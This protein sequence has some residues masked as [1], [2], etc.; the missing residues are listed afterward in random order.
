MTADLL[1]ETG[2]DLTQL[3]PIAT[4]KEVAAL[5]QTS[6]ASLAQDRYLGQ[7]IPYIKHGR[8]VRYL[9]ADVAR[10]LVTHRNNYLIP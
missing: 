5:L 9:R 3:P 6:Q 10:Y 4:A 8:L 2:I 1:A 7:G